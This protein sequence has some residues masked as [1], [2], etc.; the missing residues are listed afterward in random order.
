MAPL[1]IPSL[2]LQAAVFFGGSPYLLRIGD[3][4]EAGHYRPVGAPQGYDARIANQ[5]HAVARRQA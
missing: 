4:G 3:V 5:V 2:A 1:V